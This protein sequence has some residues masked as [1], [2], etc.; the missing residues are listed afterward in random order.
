MGR[1]YD[2]TGS[3]GT[4]LLTD[5]AKANG[6]IVGVDY[7]DFTIAVTCPVHPNG[8]PYIDDLGHAVRHGQNITL[9]VSDWTAQQFIIEKGPQAINRVFAT[10]DTEGN[11]TVLRES[12]VL[13]KDG[14]YTT[15]SRVRVFR[16]QN[17][18]EDTLRY[19]QAHLFRSY[20]LDQVVIHPHDGSLLVTVGELELF[21][22][23]V[24]H[25]DY[26]VEY[27]GKKAL[28]TQVAYQVEL[29]DGRLVVTDMVR[30]TQRTDHLVWHYVQGGRTQGYSIFAKT[31]AEAEAI[32]VRINNTMEA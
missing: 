17:Y 22:G 31:A 30:N 19:A 13:C 29:I 24:V 27:Q 4:R 15:L 32:G 1:I 26:L 7:D 21:E 16:G 18:N 25:P 10:R 5:W 14:T 28:A 12:L 6:V 23:Q 11:S 8:L 9:F 20:D 2:S 3:R